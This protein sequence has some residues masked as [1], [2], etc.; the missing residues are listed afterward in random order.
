METCN[1]H[2]DMCMRLGTI[3]ATLESLDKNISTVICDFKNHV[4][5]AEKPG[6]VR[7]RVGTTEAAIRV[8][9][10]EISVIKQGYWKACIVSGVVGGLLARLAPDLIWG[11]IEKVVK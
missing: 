4:H 5:D 1:Q 7:D 6:G 2:A 3:Q 11:F 10:G 9:R 8:L